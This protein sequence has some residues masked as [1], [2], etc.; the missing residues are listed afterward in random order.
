MISIIKILDNISATSISQCFSN[1]N[2]SDEKL[3]L[4]HFNEF[5]SIHDDYRILCKFQGQLNTGVVSIETIT[6][7][8]YYITK[9]NFL[10]QKCIIYINTTDFSPDSVTWNTSPTF[11]T[12]KSIIFTIDANTFENKYLEIDITTLAREQD[13]GINST[14]SFTILCENS[15]KNSLI[16]FYGTNSSYPPQVIINYNPASD[17]YGSFLNLSTETLPENKCISP[18][19]LLNSNHEVIGYSLDL[20]PTVYFEYNG[21]YSLSVLLA[22]LTSK[23]SI[24]LVIGNRYTNFSDFKLVN[25]IIYSGDDDILA[26]SLLNID[27]EH[28]MI[29]VIS[30][31]NIEENAVLSIVSNRISTSNTIYLSTPIVNPFNGENI[32]NVDYHF[33][34]TK[35]DCPLYIG[36]DSVVNQCGKTTTILGSVYLHDNQD[37]DDSCH[38]YI[39]N[40]NI[41]DTFDI[42]VGNASITLNNVYIKTVNCISAKNIIF[43]DNCV[44]PTVNVVN[45]SPITL[46]ISSDEKNLFI[47]DL[48][49][50][51]KVDSPS[52][53][54]ITLIG[55]FEKTHINVLENCL[56][57]GVDFFVDIPINVNIINPI[58]PLI[59]LSGNFN[60]V[61]FSIYNGLSIDILDDFIN[62]AASLTLCPPLNAANTNFNLYGSFESLYK[63]YVATSC[64]INGISG[65][66]HFTENTLLPVLRKSVA[67][68]NLTS[69][70]PALNIEIN[71]APNS[72]PPVLTLSGALDNINITAKSI[73]G[74]ILDSVNLAVLDLSNLNTSFSLTLMGTSTIS[75]QLIISN[76]I[77]IN[78]EPEA[79]DN[80]LELLKNIVFNSPDGKIIISPQMEGFDNLITAQSNLQSHFVAELTGNITLE[81][82]I[83][84][85]NK[86][87][88]PVN[89]SITSLS[90]NVTFSL[91]NNEIVYTMP[92]ADKNYINKHEAILALTL[93]NNTNNMNCDLLLRGKYDHL[94]INYEHKTAYLQN[95]GNVMEYVLAN[96]NIYA[97]ILSQDFSQPV[98]GSVIGRNFLLDL[99]GYSLEMNSIYLCDGDFIIRNGTLTPNYNLDT[100]HIL[101]SSANSYSFITLDKTVYLTSLIFD[102]ITLADINF[103]GDFSNSHYVIA[104]ENSISDVD[105]LSITNCN[106]FSSSTE[107]KLSYVISSFAKINT[108]TAN[109]FNSSNSSIL[110]SAAYDNTRILCQLSNNNFSSNLGYGATNLSVNLYQKKGTMALNINGANLFSGTDF[111]TFISESLGI[112]NSLSNSS[113]EN[114]FVNNNLCC[115]SSLGDAP[116]FRCYK[117]LNGSWIFQAKAPKVYA[118]SSD[119]DMENLISLSFDPNVDW[120]NNITSISIENSTFKTLDKDQYEIDYYN[121]LIIIKN[122][123]FAEYRRPVYLGILE[124]DTNLITIKASGY[125]DVTVNQYIQPRQIITFNSGI[126]DGIIRM[127]KEGNYTINASILYENTSIDIDATA[128]ALMVGVHP[129]NLQ[130]NCSIIDDLYISFDKSV[131]IIN[132]NGFSIRD[133]LGNQ[134][135]VY[136]KIKENNKFISIEHVPFLPNSEYT[137]LIQN[138][139]INYNGVLLDKAITWSFST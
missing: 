139:S 31:S 103:S 44:I 88:T 61:D 11:S 65:H 54:K 80:I 38:V 48:L 5:A 118:D 63:I 45:A 71:A 136:V 18:G 111:A 91:V 10:S 51:P 84:I 109:K 133:T 40:L 15:D 102:N 117:Y 86:D 6:L 56:L 107:K 92:E 21:I 69:N 3:F 19:N 126:G 77:I 52:T 12:S 90:S 66:L 75:N 115:F 72:L 89:L 116:L 9:Q 26:P 13:Y 67:L 96:P 131:E 95:Y 127:N 81:D 98:S 74:L 112:V 125:E 113:Y 82:L 30:K 59:E 25:N 34:I 22:N 100:W 62:S 114:F 138:S 101:Y 28:N 41:Y 119:N 43:E 23:S 106:F 33:H 76:P 53:S 47:T 7:R 8:L 37:L 93:S 64:T 129:K 73:G 135:K 32:Y 122:V 14:V 110:I 123:T 4:G 17:I 128:T 99:N 20:Q 132:P 42:D 83:S 29:G 137:V 94:T 1:S 16:Y 57:E 105:A 79:I 27:S 60:N 134:I 124:P 46:T 104:V 50:N 78:R 120:V 2:I 39:N 24:G 130:K 108:L 49:I 68:P 70:S 35:I 36:C 55:D 85:A 121:N 87:N 97:S 58:N